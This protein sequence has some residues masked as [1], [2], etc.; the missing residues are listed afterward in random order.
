MINVNYF[1]RAEFN[2]EKEMGESKRE[3]NLIQSCE[4]QFKNLSKMLKDLKKTHHHNLEDK[5]NLTFIY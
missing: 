5:V 2:I 4:N 3:K 1:K